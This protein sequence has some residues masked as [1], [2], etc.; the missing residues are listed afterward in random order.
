MKILGVTLATTLAVAGIS[1]TSPSL[2]AA[3]SPLSLA[4]KL[5][6]AFVQVAEDVAPSVVVIKVSKRPSAPDMSRIPE[7]FRDWFEREFQKPTDSGEPG[8]I[9]PQEYG[10]GSGV[11]IRTNGF[12]LTNRHVVAGAEE[13]AVVMRDGKEY[14][15]KI[16]GIDEQSDLAVLK[17]E[18]ENLPTASFADSDMT[19]V[20]EYAIAI[21]APLGLDYSVTIGHVSAKGRAVQMPGLTDSDFIQTDAL[22]NQGNSGGPLVNL[23]GQI[24]GI[25]TI[26]RGTGTGSTSGQFSHSGIAFAISANLAREISETLINN[27]KVVRAWL[28]VGIESLREN[29]QW[30]EEIKGLND[31]VVVTGILQNG[32]AADSDLEVEDVITAVDGEKV[33]T[34]QELKD[35]I[36][37]KKVGKPLKLSVFRNGKNLTVAVEPGTRPDPKDMNRLAFGTQATPEEQIGLRCETLTRRLAEQYNV[38]ATSG[39]I[40]TDVRAE[41]IAARAQIEPGDVITNLEGKPIATIDDLRRI[42]GELDIADGIKVKLVNENG[43]KLRLLQSR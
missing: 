17:I 24:I 7:R 33:F 21:G 4:R 25:N 3:E 37:P 43:K 5:N 40:V 1:F 2:A 9:R 41:S 35:A 13:V 10:Q 28:G 23:D 32:P 8:E 19:R 39:V 22:I 42:L 38:K 15:A 31:G 29:P 26:I 16:Q 11:I 18:A 27:G 12:I 14:K 34:V 30:R 20:G 36:R 6:Q